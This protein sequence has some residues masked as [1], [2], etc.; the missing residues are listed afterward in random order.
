MK[1]HTY[2]G[3]GLFDLTLE[4]QLQTSKSYTT[5][6]STK[7]KCENPVPKAQDQTKQSWFL[8]LKGKKDNNQLP[9]KELHQ[10]DFSE[11]TYRIK[12]SGLYKY[13]FKSQNFDNFTYYYKTVI[14]LL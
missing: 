9:V 3:G 1:G 6:W 10:K 12:E 2:A 14:F 4:H 13:V 8:D 5:Y 11:G 7:W